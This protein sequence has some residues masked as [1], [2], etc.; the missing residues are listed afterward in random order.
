MIGF[1]FVGLALMA[2]GADAIGSREAGTVQIRSLGE[3]WGILHFP[4]RDAFL[5]WGGAKLPPAAMDPVV[6]SIMAVPAWALF[7]IIGI[8]LLYLFRQRR[9]AP[10]A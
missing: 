6:S 9:Q 10:P 7:A 5:A 1:V 8:A 3:L 2:L 4:S